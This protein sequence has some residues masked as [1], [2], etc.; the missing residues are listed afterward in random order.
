[1]G[2]INVS[3][4]KSRCLQVFKGIAS[5]K[6]TGKTRRETPRWSLILV[7]LRNEGEQTIPDEF[8]RFSEQ[9]LGA[10]LAGC[11]DIDF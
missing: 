10:L 1:M 8:L 7:K 11:F 5:L 9:L 6:V 3:I 2:L 4:N